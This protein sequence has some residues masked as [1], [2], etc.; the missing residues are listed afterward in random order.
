VAAV[1]E[2]ECGAPSFSAAAEVEPGLLGLE[3]AGLGPVR[4][5]VTPAQAR[6][7]RDLGA[8]ARYGHG[9]KTLT[10]ASV[11]DTW[12]IPRQAVTVRWADGFAPLLDALREELGLPS[13]CGLRAEFHSMLVYERGQF[14]L[15]HQDSEKDDAMVGTLVVTLPSRHTGGEL[16][17]ER[18]GTSV[19]H[20]GS[21]SKLALAAFYADCRHEV[22]PIKS[23]NR[24]TLTFNLL[25]DG[26]SAPVQETNTTAAA[27]LARHLRDHFTTAVAPAY[28]RA[29]AVPPDRLVYLLDHEYTERGL[30]WARL[31]GGDAARAALLRAA[32]ERAGCRVMLALCEIQETWEAYS[33]DEED[34]WY[35]DRAGDEEDEDDD[36][37][38]GH[39]AGDYGAD[40]DY[41]LNDLVDSSTR[42]VRWTDPDA[43]RTEKIALG[44]DETELCAGAANSALSPYEQ[45]YEGYMGNYGNTLDR[46]YRR[47]ALVLFPADREFAN[48]AEASPHWAMTQIGKRARVGDLAG[49]RADAADLA[50]FWAASIRESPQP[51]ALVKALRTAYVLED[52]ATA[53]LLLVPFRVGHLT[54]AAAAPLARLADQYGAEWACT[55][56][57]GW[58]GA[59]SPRG[60]EFAFTF[61]RERLEWYA[62][63]PNLCQA[64]QGA[65]AD[66]G[67]A[68]QTL[69]DLSWQRLRTEADGLSAVTAPSRRDAALAEL[70][71]PLASVLTAAENC[72]P[73][74][75][76]ERIMQRL[77]EL[78]EGTTAWLL[79]AVREAAA[80]S[81]QQRPG[82]AFETVAAACGRRLRNRLA[83]PV[84]AAGDWSITASADCSC[85]LCEVLS[86]FLKDP[87]RRVHEWPLAKDN[88]RHIHSRIDR[89][90][91]PVSHQ[92]RRQ[93][94]P[95]TLV[96]A[97]QDTLFDA[98]RAARTRDEA[99]LAWLAATWPV[100]AEHR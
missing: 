34:D 67:A 75:L 69:A 3:V 63:L 96:L 47:A 61:G 32:A 22:R 80:R 26:A 42:L 15:P 85:A 79:S 73:G 78:G 28:S 18:G 64:L 100:A 98:E 72:G 65:G 9:T 10:D 44:V 89:Y 5:P 39:D 30:G 93:G 43:G 45:Q 51:D 94:R 70:G 55:L 57:R 16:I 53:T 74:G 49:A 31:K 81:E 29:P 91:L 59:D 60:F 2:R 83:R 56:L 6:K 33:A 25:L 66:V 38:A 23:G 1:L 52:A 99:D 14:F 50:P 77:V 37:K 7:L 21:A 41:E 40:R 95:Y 88:R 24:V 19:Q 54:G 46:W 20:R 84:R 58:F 92:T 13:S 68:A 17:V 82:G 35:G 8:P 36:E 87:A 71:K 90:E 11:R 27:D 48:R 86:A 97:K 12:E 62:A 4:L 76:A